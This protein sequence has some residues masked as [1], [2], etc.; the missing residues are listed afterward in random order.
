M[1]ETIFLLVVVGGIKNYRPGGV[2]SGM[3]SRG[4]DGPVHGDSAIASRFI[5]V[6][7]WWKSLLATLS[8]IAGVGIASYG[9]NS[10]IV[11]MCGR[12]L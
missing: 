10:L 12:S 11:V 4:A 8:L 5:E 3:N 6:A 2:G 7:S 9:R 1:I